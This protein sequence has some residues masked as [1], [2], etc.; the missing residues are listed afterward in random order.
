MNQR[1]ADAYLESR[2]LTAAPYQ[3]HL[4]VV[5][6]ALLHA[7]KAGDALDQRDHEVSFFALSKSRECLD[8]LILGLNMEAAP[9]LSESIKQLLLFVHRCLRM[10]DLTHDSKHVRDGIKILELHRENWLLAIERSI[11]EVNQKTSSDEPKTSFSLV[12]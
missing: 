1:A 7:R 2:V 5:D 6:A 4:M 9:E 10:A 3:L 8:E 11:G 12:T